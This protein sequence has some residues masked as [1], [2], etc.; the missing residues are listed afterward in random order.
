V[1]CPDDF[2]ETFD[3]F[4]NQQQKKMLAKGEEVFELSKKNLF[5]FLVFHT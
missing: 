2:G 3:F 5:L 1:I 4:F